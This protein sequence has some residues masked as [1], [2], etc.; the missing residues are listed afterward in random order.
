MQCFRYIYIFFIIRERTKLNFNVCDFVVCLFVLEFMVMGRK[1]VAGECKTNYESEEKRRK[2]KGIAKVSVFKFPRNENEKQMWMAA[3]PNILEKPPTEHVGVC[4]LHWPFGY[5]KITVQ[6][7]KQRPKFPPSEF[8]TPASFSRQT[9]ASSDRD[10][11]RRSVDSNSRHERS[12]LNKMEKDTIKD[13]TDLKNYCANIPDISFHATDDAIDLIKLEGFPP[14]VNFPICITKEMKVSAFKKHMQVPLR[15]IIRSFTAELKLF[16]EVKA[17][18]EKLLSFE[19]PAAS[20]LEK[21]SADIA[22]LSHDCDISNTQTKQLDFMSRQLSLQSVKS[23]GRRYCVQTAYDALNLFL[24]N[25]NC[26]KELRKLVALPNDVTLRQY[27]GK[28]GTPG[29]ENE[30]KKVVT[31]VFSKLEGPQKYCKILVDEIYIKPAVRYTCRHV[32][33]F[34]VDD[35]QKPASTVLAI[36]IAPLMGAPAFVARLFPLS[37]LDAPF[38][39]EQILAVINIVH[40]AS[41]LVFLVMNDNLRTN[42][43]FFTMMHKKF[44]SSSQYSIKHPVINEVFENLFLLYDPTHL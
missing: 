29:I 6:G 7:G 37:S 16:S 38:L 33:G 2:E 34:S 1:C 39:I 3:L 26:Y 25:K 5:E 10:V 12:K 22:N 21:I 18:I 44:G 27:F 42:Q 35:P 19:I 24:R 41:G 23:G 43:S 4:E 15:D 30:C 17:I 9:R 40:E 20:F 36:L 8:E 28:L 31:T 11:K 14:Q 32:I 13:W